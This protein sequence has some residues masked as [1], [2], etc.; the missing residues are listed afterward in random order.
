[1]FRRPLPDKPP[2]Y[3]TVGEVAE[4]LRVSRR[5]IERVIRSGSLPKYKLG[6]R[7]LLKRADV[8]TYARKLRSPQ[9]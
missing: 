1:M 6:R 3:M 2:A 5:Q 7:T 4:L 8:L 9:E